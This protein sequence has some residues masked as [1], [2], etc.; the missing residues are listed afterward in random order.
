MQFGHSVWLVCEYGWDAECSGATAKVLWEVGRDVRDQC[1][2]GGVG[3]NCWV[4]IWWVGKHDK[5]HTPDWHIWAFHKVLPMPT[6]NNATTTTTP[7]C[8]CCCSA[9]PPPLQPHSQPLIWRHQKLLTRKFPQ[10]FK[11][12]NYSLRLWLSHFPPFDQAH[13]IL[14]CLLDYGQRG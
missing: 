12:H 11:N 7:K 13:Y 1:I 9:S 6:S 4:W 14:V 10:G 2:C 8:H 3:A 5:L